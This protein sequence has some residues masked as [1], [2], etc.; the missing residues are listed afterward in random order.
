MWQ[1]QFAASQRIADSGMERGV[2][3][4]SAPAQDGALNRTAPYTLDGMDE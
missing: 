1:I 2:S 4:L 3:M